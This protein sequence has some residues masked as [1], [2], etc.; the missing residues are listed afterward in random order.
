MA[1]QLNDKYKPLFTT[2]KRYIIVTGGRGSGKSFG[3]TTFLCLLAYELYHRILYTRYTL[4]SA[5]ISII[6]E[7]VDKITRL[8]AQTVFKVSQYVIQHTRTGVEILFKGIKTSSGNQTA[9]L[10][11]L[12]GITTWVVDEA[13]EVPDAETFDK[14][15]L[16]IRETSA[17]NRVILILNP[18]TREHW[19]WK[20]FFEDNHDLVMIDGVQVPI[21]THPDVCHIHTTYLDNIDNLSES[22]LKT[23]DEIRRTDK[24]RYEHEIIGGWRLNPDGVLFKKDELKRF[25]RADIRKSEAEAIFGYVD[26]ADQGDDSYCMPV[27]H[28][29]NQKVFITDAI[30]SKEG[31]EVTL[32][33]TVQ[34]I[35]DQTIYDDKKQIVK[36]IDHVRVEANN[37]GGEIIRG[38]R[39]VFDPSKIL[40]VTNTANKHTRILLSR[41]FVLRY[42]HF[43][44]ESEYERGSDYDL[45]VKEILA[46]LKDGSS[47]HDDAPDSLSGL[48]TMAQ[49]F[50]PHLFMDI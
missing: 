7:F 47:D 27:A 41:S 16:S 24:Q 10:K 48:T 25:K 35:N 40:A 36:Q 34:M 11:S 4:V 18:T 15:D 44:D 20:R 14:I 17:Q 1:V 6:P 3:V 43:L 9:N 12:Q 49:S 28:I 39:R 23:I 33:K 37:Q 19:I 29:Y 2:K 26:V 13:E 22:F 5:E 38:L 31:I 42:V 32:P 50:L 21:S 45:F 46:Y 8:G 30:F